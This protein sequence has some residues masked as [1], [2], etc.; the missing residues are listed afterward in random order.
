[1]GQT[2]GKDHNWQ[3]EL[4][5]Q[6]DV[7]EEQQQREYSNEHKQPPQQ[8]RYSDDKSAGTAVQHET[9]ALIKKPRRWTDY[10]SWQA[11][12]GL[13]LSDEDFTWLKVSEIVKFIPYT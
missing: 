13:N 6:A 3:P 2:H 7:E 10:R 5:G 4:T 8:T 9:D 11:I 12:P 1:M